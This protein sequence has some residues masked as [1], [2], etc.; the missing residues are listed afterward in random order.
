MVYLILDVEDRRLCQD[1][2]WRG[3]ANF[4]SY[5]ECVKEYKSRGHALRAARH[6]KGTVF[7]VPSGAT[8]DASGE[9]RDENGQVRKW[10]EFEVRG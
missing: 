8:V 10:A 2:R 6:I 3:H 4:G 9:L 5:K 1:H 7:G